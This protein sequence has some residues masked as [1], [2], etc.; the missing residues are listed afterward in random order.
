MMARAMATTETALRRMRAICLALP[1][2]SESDHFGESYFRAGRRGFASCGEK[3]GVCR[4][5]VQ[6]EPAHAKRLLAADARFQPYSRAQAAVWI[7][8]AD[9][10]DWDEIEALVL[11][12][13]RLNAA[14]KRSAGR[15][16]RR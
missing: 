6:L 4:I 11:E 1:D 3:D 13:H 9:V 7:D 5:V 8:V 2:T 15:T 12:S 14:P 10:T 16:R